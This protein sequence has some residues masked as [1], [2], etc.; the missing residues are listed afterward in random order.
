VL[1]LTLNFTHSI[2][3]GDGIRTIVQLLGPDLAVFV[4]LCAVP[5]ANSAPSLT[6]MCILWSFYKIYIDYSSE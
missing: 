1:K 3:E 6:Y 2:I 5:I 4:S